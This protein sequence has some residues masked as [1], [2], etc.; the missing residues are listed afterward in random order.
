M[1]ALLRDAIFLAIGAA[2]LWWMLANGNPDDVTLGFFMG[3][4]GGTVIVW[5]IAMHLAVRGKRPVEQVNV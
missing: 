3:I 4:V 1:P 5:I 2:A